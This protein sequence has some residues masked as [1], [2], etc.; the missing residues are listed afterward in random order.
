M[1][2]GSKCPAR[3]ADRLTPEVSWYSCH[4]AADCRRR[5]DRKNTRTSL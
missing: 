3:Y 4:D 5:P 2:Y 1:R